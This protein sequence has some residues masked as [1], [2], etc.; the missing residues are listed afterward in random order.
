MNQTPPT[1]SAPETA[2]PASPWSW[3]AFMFDAAF[4]VA[5]KQYALLPWYLLLF[6]PFV[7]FVFIVAFK[8]YLGTKGRALAAASPQFANH[9]EFAGFMKGLDHAGKVLFFVML[10]F[11]AIAIIL[12][13]AGFA[14]PVWMGMNFGPA[15]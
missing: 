12:S 8:I 15:E 10:A 5:I 1:T 2:A 11:V 7:N 4:L 9:D 14:L 6:V 13:L 3:G